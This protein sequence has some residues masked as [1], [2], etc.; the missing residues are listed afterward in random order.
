MGERAAAQGVAHGLLVT[1]WF[2]AAAGFV[3]AAG[4]WIISPHADLISASPAI[5]TSTAGPG[6]KGPGA[7]QG[8]GS[9]QP[10]PARSAS[11]GPAKN[12]TG[13]GSGSTGEPR[14]TVRYYG[15]AWSSGKFFVLITL[16]ES[17]ANKHW[18]LHF[19]LAGDQ[20]IQAQ[21]AIWTPSGQAAG[22]AGKLTPVPGHGQDDLH[23]GYPGSQLPRGVNFSVYGTGSDIKPTNCTLNGKACLFAV[24]SLGA[25]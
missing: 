5:G 23:F 24:E 2:A 20:D 15:H 1:P 9:G 17:F 6:D 10:A 16:P 21:N 13:G 25:G 4:L 14:V 19:Q 7:G 18:A 3:I 12:K 22:S 11:T 8:D